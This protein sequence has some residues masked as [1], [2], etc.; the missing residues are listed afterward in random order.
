MSESVFSR[1]HRVIRATGESAVDRL[2]RA[3]SGS[4]M[5]QAIREVDNA[6]DQTRAQQEAAVQRRLLAIAQQR[7]VRDEIAS[8]NEQARF[9][10]DK[11]REDLARA[12]V[13]R[14]MECEAELDRLQ[15][16]E[17]RADEEIGRL[18]ACLA[19]IEARKRQMET[20][21]DAFEAARQ[22]AS[23][24]GEFPVARKAARAEE[25]FSRAMAAAGT[26]RPVGR[27]GATAFAEVRAMRREAEISE[28][29]EGLRAGEPASAGPRAKKGKKG[30]G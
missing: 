10:M 2:E 9:A 28:R 3:T 4:L 29:L 27:S 7:I 14:Q 16:V 22:E 20:E 25:T 23:S 30:N 12:T 21:L 13:A 6:A 15:A 8:L 1:F 17:S 26:G 11:G 18:D 5:R 19:D 24:A